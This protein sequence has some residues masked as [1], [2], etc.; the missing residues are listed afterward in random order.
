MAMQ[1]CPSCDGLTPNGGVCLH[2]DRPLPVRSRWLALFAPVGAVLLA[3]CYGPAGSY[4]GSALESPPHPGA[5]DEDHDGSWTPEDCNDHDSK[6]YPGAA[7]PDGD[8]IDQNCDGVD[9]VADK[10]QMPLPEPG[11]ADT[12][13]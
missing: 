7:D 10:A 4:R 13:L 2:C 8:G 12:P 3:A 1:A 11:S 6:I 9:G 5:L